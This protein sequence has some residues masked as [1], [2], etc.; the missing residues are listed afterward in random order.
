MIALTD[1]SW[2]IILTA[3]I[4]LVQCVQGA[5]ITQRTLTDTNICQSAGQRREC[6]GMDARWTRRMIILSTEYR[7]PR[8]AACCRTRESHRYRLDMQT[9]RTTDPCRLNAFLVVA[10]RTFPVGNHHRTSHTPAPRSQDRRSSA[11]FIP[12]SFIY[13]IFLRI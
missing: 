1:D 6:R 4:H 5:E 3:N 2:S 10:C 8:Y 12:A 9:C 11:G 7:V 13:L